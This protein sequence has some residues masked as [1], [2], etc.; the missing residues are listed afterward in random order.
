M[1]PLMDVNDN[2]GFLRRK[3]AQN[4]ST[5]YEDDP[6]TKVGLRPEEESGKID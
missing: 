5:F 4:A 1:W 2:V 6:Y 3:F